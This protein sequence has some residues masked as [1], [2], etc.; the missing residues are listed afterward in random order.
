MSIPQTTSSAAA[1][2]A[3]VVQWTIA[4]AIQRIPLGAWWGLAG[5]LAAVSA[6]GYAIAHWLQSR[7]LE[8]TESGLAFDRAQPRLSLVLG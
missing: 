4:D 6:A 8:N 2:I 7:K 5:A 3:D 1:P